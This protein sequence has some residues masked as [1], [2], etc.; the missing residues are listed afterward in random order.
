MTGCA[1]FL[2][3][4]RESNVTS[5][6]PTIKLLECVDRLRA[7]DVALSPCSIF[8]DAEPR[9]AVGDDVARGNGQG[10]RAGKEMKRFGSQGSRGGG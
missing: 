4:E 1:D 7:P 8:F 5:R 3:A 9:R 2:A 6:L 10:K